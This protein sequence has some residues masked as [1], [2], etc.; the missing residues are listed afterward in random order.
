MDAR[1][2][3]NDDIPGTV[4]TAAIGRHESAHRFFSIQKQRC[5]DENSLG[6][7]KPEKKHSTCFFFSTILA[8]RAKRH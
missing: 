7:A 3:S 4:G 6:V 1:K 2:T 8:Q 5:H